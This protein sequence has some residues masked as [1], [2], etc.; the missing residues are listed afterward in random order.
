MNGKKGLAVVLVTA[1]I[2]C[3]VGAVSWKVG[4]EENVITM[5]EFY[6]SGATVARNKVITIES[7][8][9]LKLLRTYVDE[10][11]S[12]NLG[13]FRLIQDIYWSNFE[14]EWDEAS[15]RVGIYENGEML[16]ATDSSSCFKNYMSD[17]KVDNPFWNKEEWKFIGTETY[18]MLGDFDGNGFTIHGLWGYYG[19]LFGVMHGEIRNL[20]IENFYSEGD[21]VASLC[22]ET[23]GD[24]RNCEI[25]K[26]FCQSD[27]SSRYIG[28]IVAIV[29]DGVVVEDCRADFVI[30]LKNNH[31]NTWYNVTVGGIAGSTCGE[32]KFYN[33]VAKGK[34]EGDYF[35]QFGSICGVIGENGMKTIKNCSSFVD[36]SGCAVYAGGII[37]SVCQPY[38]DTFA[39][40]KNCVNEGNLKIK[41]GCALGG[42]V[43]NLEGFSRYENVSLDMSECINR[44][45]LEGRGV[46]GGLVGM[47]GDPMKIVNCTNE[48]DV[49]SDYDVFCYGETKTDP[50]AGGLVGG[51]DTEYTG[52]YE[53][54]S[55]IVN[56]ANL[57]NVSSLYGCC[58]GIVGEAGVGKDPIRI[59]NCY[60]AGDVSTEE[61]IKGVI[62][63]DVHAGIFQYC[64]YLSQSECK[65]V[66]DTSQTNG[67][68]Q[69]D[70]IYPVTEKQLKGTETEKRIGTIGYASAFSL[71]KALN[72]WVENQSG[73]VYYGWVQEEFGPVWKSGLYLEAPTPTPSPTPRRTAMPT[74]KPTI[75]PTKQPTPS[76]TVTPTA[77]PVISS[78]APSV[79][80]NKPQS[81]SEPVP[82]VSPK[83]VASET[84]KTKKTKKTKYAAPVFV[85]K[86]KRT[87]SGKRYIQIRLK[88]YKGTNLEIWAKLKTTKNF[89]KLKIKNNNIR[90]MKKIFNFQYSKP[91]GILTFKLRTYKGK[92]KSRV[93]SYQS[94]EKRIRL[95]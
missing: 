61:G 78:E 49:S 11:K 34:V 27:S 65:A 93:Y 19:S 8:E 9:E 43:G 42:I 2:L 63:G 81:M 52:K 59:Y 32:V 82:A 64:Y 28:G 23:Y 80:V 91:K 46:V 88:Q 53:N 92:G 30:V 1:L 3:S 7:K 51:T 79:A 38:D 87:S 72:H 74:L 41:E 75:T 70:N 10:G 57:G 20:K 22:R 68:K 33:N 60:S 94:K 48:G 85:L 21:Y 66:G 62:A 39:K 31:N 6:E 90:K 50:V 25:A 89:T 4:A 40:L 13:T 18:P 5:T 37:G 56:C 15:K 24:I 29:R 35:Y 73:Q 55:R 84:K 83:S 69:M 86:K 58:G 76:P 95:S 44:G 67:E 54:N 47:R 26:M 14:F 17:T 45:E 77:V 12:T 36:F 71:C 16:A